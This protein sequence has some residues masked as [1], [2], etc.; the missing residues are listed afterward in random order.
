MLSLLLLVSLVTLLSL[1]IGCATHVESKV[2]WKKGRIEKEEGHCE[3]D[4]SG[5]WCRQS[6]ID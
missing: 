2:G 4:A 6:N 5:I 3:R 1:V